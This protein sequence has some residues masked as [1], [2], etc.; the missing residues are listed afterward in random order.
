MLPDCARPRRKVKRARSLRIDRET[1]RCVHSRRKCNPLPV[2]GTVS[3]S[4]KRTVAG[5]PDAAVF[6][7]SRQKHIES[8]AA[9]GQS[10]RKRFGLVIP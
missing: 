5:I 2:F 7:T 3:L 4:G 1:V 8:A 9:P 6:R 10:P